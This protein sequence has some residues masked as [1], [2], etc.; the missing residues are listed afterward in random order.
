MRVPATE[1][2][3][4]DVLLVEDSA[5]DVRLAREAFRASL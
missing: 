1:I 2:S 4:L 5:G 3:S